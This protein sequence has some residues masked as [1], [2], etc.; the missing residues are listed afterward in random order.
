MD[1]VAP[2]AD[3]NVLQI[4][5]FGK[6]G[7]DTLNVDS[8]A[9]TVPVRI[10]GGTGHDLFTVGKNTLDNILGL[11]RTGLNSPFGLGPV[12]LVGG[13]GQDSVVVT[14]EADTG[15][16]TGNL[17]VFRETRLGVVGTVEVGIVSGLGM[18]L[19]GGVGIKTVTEGNGSTNEVQEIHV[20]DAISGTYR[21]SF[22]GVSTGN[23]A[24]GASA[25]TLKTALE[26][27]SSI[28]AGNVNVTLA[29][30][31]THRVYT[32]TFQ[33]GKGNQNVESILPDAT[34]LIAAG[35]V[36]FEGFETV[37]VRLGKG[38]DS[39]TV[40]GD[41]I[42]ESLPQNRQTSVQ[43][44]LN[45][46]TGMTIVEGGGGSDTIGVIATNELDRSTLL[47]TSPGPLVSATTF[48]HGG[49]GSTSEVQT[50]TVNGAGRGVGF[51]TI[52]YRYAETRAIAFGGGASEVQD[53]LVALPLIGT[54][55]SGAPNVS[56]SKGLVGGDDVYTITFQ[57]GLANMDLPQVVPLIT[58]LAIT[59]D[60]AG[61]TTK[62]ITTTAGKPRRHHGRSPAGD[63]SRRDG[64][65]DLQAEVRVRR[66][67]EHY[68]RPGLR[69]D[70]ATG[71]DRA[72][73]SQPHRRR[74]RFRGQ[75]HG[76]RRGCLHHHVPG[77][78][79]NKDVAADHRLDR[80]GRGRR[81]ER[82]VDQ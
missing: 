1:Y 77:A 32:V 64:T 16:N 21:L 31:G 63:D 40:G 11:A 34:N 69:R 20:D 55:A 57:N 73:S 36:E 62:M 38:D 71:A 25:A 43:E 74:Q 54:N 48:T 39:F 58:P 65:D 33:N 6:G 5:V 45:T 26:G 51:F 42:L 13:A 7:N 46:L 50:V 3:A 75:G 67:L 82:A 52:Q 4:K 68:I 24:I 15:T 29:V 81:V 72:R 53:A 49:G 56:V 22:G 27:L 66:R 19:H 8:T 9:L 2:A 60:T 10:D 14:D 47:T 78:L 18:T 79:G 28:G 44:F 80:A 35:R 23:I 76:R 41:A 70:A 30:N 12:V 37:D 17:T 61:I 59:G